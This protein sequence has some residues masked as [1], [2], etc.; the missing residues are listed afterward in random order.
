M[1]KFPFQRKNGSA[2]AGSCGEMIFA[3]LLRQALNE[4]GDN[5]LRQLD[6]NIDASSS[7]GPRFILET[8]HAY[9]HRIRDRHRRNG[10]S[11]R[12]Y[13][14][15]VH[16]ANRQIGSPLFLFDVSAS[17]E[18]VQQPIEHDETQRVLQNL[19]IM[20]FNVHT[21]DVRLSDGENHY[22]KTDEGSWSISLPRSKSLQQMMRIIRPHIAHSEKT[23]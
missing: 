5:N 22:Q 6:N 3:V 14:G 12:L 10:G 17:R 9:K 15:V 23:A 7:L 2:I 11:T 19:R 18:F 21:F 20:G 8:P 4:R 1:G 16:S 13:D